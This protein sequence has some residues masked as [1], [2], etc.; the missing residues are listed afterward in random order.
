MNPRNPLD[1]IKQV[2]LIVLMG[3]GFF[4]NAQENALEKN[5]AEGLSKAK[6]GDYIGAIQSFDKAIEA[7]PMDPHAWYN[8][9]MAK[10]MLG[11]YESALYDFGTCIALKP[12]YE[13][14]WYNRGL[15]KLYLSQYDGALFDL[16]QAIQIDREYAAA[17]YYRA[18]IYELKGLF[19]F[20]CVDYRNAGAKGY[21][22]PDKIKAACLDTTYSGFIKN[23]ILYIHESAKSKKYGYSSA[24]PICTGNLENVE[25]YLR[26]L[27]AP[28]GAFVYYEMVQKDLHP[29]VDITFKNKRGKKTTNRI[30]F[31]CTKYE[32]PLRIR[33]MKTFK[34]PL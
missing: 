32:K 14:V 29:V 27:R 28:N 30:Y 20:A 6:N 18:Y 19:E 8:R 10:N 17:Y 34:L 24:H 9:G 12:A 11:D 1:R 4:G 21:K 2:L 31:D 13:K 16:S 7:L 23:P 15:T 5:H 3:F 22:V 26:L 33:G 25:R